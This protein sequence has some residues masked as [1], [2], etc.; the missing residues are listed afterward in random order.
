MLW[1]TSSPWLLIL[2]ISFLIKR[3]SRCIFF[4]IPQVFY[5]SSYIY[6]YLTKIHKLWSSSGIFWPVE[7]RHKF[8]T[9]IKAKIRHS[10]NFCVSCQCGLCDKL[11]FLHLLTFNSKDTT[12]QAEHSS[13]FSSAKILENCPNGGWSIHQSL[14][15]V[16]YTQVLQLKRSHP[17]NTPPQ[18][19]WPQ[20]TCW[21]FLGSV[22][23]QWSLKQPWGILNYTD[24]MLSAQ[25]LR[26][27][28]RWGKYLFVQ[29]L[30]IC[31]LHHQSEG[32]NIHIS[33]DLNIASDI[34]INLAQYLHLL[35]TKTQ[36]QIKPCTS[37]PKFDDVL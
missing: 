28:K 8:L 24:E 15:D 18:G 4:L 32:G 37:C 1:H 25:K 31:H 19:P 5:I 2:L 17:A 29:F 3:L 20:H 10:R 11:T 21:K 30:S 6:V 23:S 36:L 33:F 12:L 34:W 35:S 9:N 14:L 26:D 7:S 27:G 22:T 13:E 16:R